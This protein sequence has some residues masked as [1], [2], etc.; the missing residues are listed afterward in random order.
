MSTNAAEADSDP[1]EGEGIRAA[2]S[3]PALGAIGAEA[4]DRA[5][6]E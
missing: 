4:F 3:S 5:D 6:S 1:F 2:A